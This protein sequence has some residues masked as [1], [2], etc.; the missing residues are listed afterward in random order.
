MDMSII[1]L[2][3]L[4]AFAASIM[5]FWL[6][7]SLYVY[8]DAKTHSDNPVLWMIIAMFVPSFFGVIIYFLV[9]RTKKAPSDHKYGLISIISLILTFLTTIAFIVTVFAASELPVWDGV[10]IGMYENNLGTHWELSYKT[11]GERHERTLN[12]TNEELDNIKLE[13]SCGE[14]ESYLLFYQ[15]DVVKLIDIS[16]TENSVLD[17]SEFSEGVINIVHY[18][19]GGRDVRF[20]LDW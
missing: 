3:L 8:N 12:L 16:N 19:N 1:V 15:N 9:G 4:F 14:G 6:F 18:N 20:K 7:S 5:A 10:S 17:M 11:S 13:A 2:I